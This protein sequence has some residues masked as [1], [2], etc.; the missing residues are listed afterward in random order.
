M[1]VY[2]VCSW[3][4]FILYTIE[5]KFLRKDWLR[6]QESNFF[7]AIASRWRRNKYTNKI[8]LWRTPRFSPF[9]SRKV[10]IHSVS[11]M[12]Q[13]HVIVWKQFFS[14]SWVG[15]KS[16]TTVDVFISQWYNSAWCCLHILLRNT[17]MPAVLC[18][19]RPVKCKHR[20]TEPWGLES[21]RSVF[22]FCTANM[23]ACA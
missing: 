5:L 20:L 13:V 10:F 16:R 3:W 6:E 15:I 9:F 2:I 8:L 1:C 23:C 19:N 12:P 14:L 22:R 4:D 17:L 11:C 18:E 7:F 21:P